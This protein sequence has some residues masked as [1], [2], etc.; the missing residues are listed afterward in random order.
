MA[1]HQQGTCSPDIFTLGPSLW[2]G[3]GATALVSQL[4][5]LGG[6]LPANPYAPVHVSWPKSAAA[7]AQGFGVSPCQGDTA[8]CS[9]NFQWQ[10]TVALQAIPGT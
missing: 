8:V 3:G 5:L 10:G 4:R 7:L 6:R 9:E 1:P 2:D